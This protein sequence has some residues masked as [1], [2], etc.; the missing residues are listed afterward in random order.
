MSATV[1]NSDLNKPRLISDESVSEHVL[2]VEG[3][4]PPH[5]AYSDHMPAFLQWPRVSA[6]YAA[7]LGLTFLLMSFQPLYHTDLW[8]HLAYG[9]LIVETGAIPGTEPLMPLAAGMRFVDSAWLSQVIGYLGYRSFGPTAL[10]FMHATLITGTLLMLSLLWHSKT[11]AVWTI[12]AGLV[13]FA[14]LN[15]QQWLVIRPQLAGVLAFVVL[16]AV[17]QTRMNGTLKLLTLPVLF[18]LWS[19]LHGSFFVGLMWLGL[20]AAGRGLDLLFRTRRFSALFHDPELRRR[21][22]ALELAVAAALVNPYSWRL[23]V[24]VLTF[25]RNPNLADLTEWEPLSVRDF[26]GQAAAVA[27]LVIAAL[28]R[29]TPRRISFAEVLAILF[30]GFQALWSQRFLVWWSPLLTTAIVIHAAAVWQK[31]L[32]HGQFPAASPRHG[33]WSVVTAGLIFISFAYTPFGVRVL[34]GKEPNDRTLYFDQTPR[35]VVAHLNKTPPVGQIFNTYE[36][37]DYLSW[38]GPK[39]MKVFVNSHAHLVP[40][41]IWR[42]YLTIAA[43]SGDYREVLDRYGINTMVLDKQERGLLIRRMRDDAAFTV[44]YEDAVGVVFRRTKPI[45]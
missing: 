36:W 29:I 8:G 26:T 5:A 41:E 7:V 21:V 14:A 28:Y 37:G 30:F 44:S 38:A 42:S 19:N 11:R 2:P 10:Q 23:F 40:R 6:A 12:L 27:C 9:R 33:K 35:G 4:S 17:M 13:L 24:E 34:H 20:F 3:E 1:S 43:A 31:Y 32:A 22:F 15:W 39:E 18:V 16:L 45:H 25:G